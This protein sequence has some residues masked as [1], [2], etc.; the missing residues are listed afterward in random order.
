MSKPRSLLMC[1]VEADP[2]G[3]VSLCGKINS[4][5][6]LKHMAKELSDKQC[7]KAK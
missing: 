3:F 1:Q 4:I 7:E 2:V 5:A 6:H